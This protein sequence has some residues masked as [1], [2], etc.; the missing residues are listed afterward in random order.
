MYVRAIAS[1]RLM[2][3]DTQHRRETHH[4]SVTSRLRLQSNAEKMRFGG[5]GRDMLIVF[6][7]AFVALLALLWGE[8]DE[9]PFWDALWSTSAGA[10]ELSRNGFDYPELLAQPG[11]RAGGPG[12]HAASV[13]TPI[14]GSFLL[15]LGPEAGLVAGHVF[16]VALGAALTT[17]TFALA[18]RF[19]GRRLSIMIAAATTLLPVVLQQIADPYLEL[20]LALL[21]VLAVMAVLDGDR[22]RLALLGALAVWVKPTGLILLP[23]IGLMGCKGEPRRWGKNAMAV[24]IAGLPFL[25]QQMA[26]SITTE[27]TGLD[28]T[29]DGT[30]ILLRSA[31]SSLV[32]TT[33]VFL[34]AAMV[35]LVFLRRRSEHE[36]FTRTVGLLT[37]GFVAIML[38]TIVASQGITILP[39]YYVALL[40]LWIILVAMRLEGDSPKAA[41]VFLGLLIGFSVLNFHGHLYPYANHHQAFL[42]ERAVGAASDYR[43]LMI[44]GTNA[45]VSEP[46]DAMIGEEA[47]EFR[48]KY[49]ELGY[50]A[51][52]QENFIPIRSL[53]RELPDSFAWL[54]EPRSERVNDIL[55]PI[56]MQGGWAI[57]RKTVYD[58]RWHSEIVIASK[59]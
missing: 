6:A 31:I 36:L 43:E 49:P 25:L 16:F 39:R 48:L 40:P 12:S 35:G 32:I 52:A 3:Q 45:L 2:T 34:L 53:P 7:V 22:T 5:H 21:L 55:E 56:A 13:I 17:A 9:P 15:L 37:G 20:P 33:D 24:L 44:S 54:D 27:A 46:V 51:E 29:W 11:F 58:G 8:L 14:L 26:P 38:Y 4:G 47:L 42:A 59:N 23:V 19:F 30:W 28:P 18:R 1:V 10:A 57:T 50:V 41:A